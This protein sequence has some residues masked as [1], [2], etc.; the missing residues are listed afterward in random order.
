MVFYSANSGSMKALLPL[1]LIFSLHY[2]A[3]CQVQSC[4]VENTVWSE[5]FGTGTYSSL[6][7]GKT[8]YTYSSSTLVEGNYRLAKNSQGGQLWHNSKDHTG[9]T[10]G[11]M[12]L[13]NANGG[14]GE[15]YRDTVYNL[16]PGNF[17]MVSF[18]A[19]NT[20]VRGTC[21]GST[22]NPRLQFIAEA[23]NADGSF[24]QLSSFYSNYLNATS[25]PT[26]VKVSGNFTLPINVSAI[27]FRI[28]NTTTGTCGVNLAIDD[29]S[30]G[31]CA[32]AASLPAKGLNLT[33]QKRTNTVSL[34]WSTL[35]EFNTEKFEAEKS[36]D[37]RNWQ[38]IG[39][40]KA[41][42]NST[43]KKAYVMEDITAGFDQTYYRIKL[44]DVDGKLTYSNIQVVRD[45]EG[46]TA[47]R[48]V[49]NPFKQ[50]TTVQFSAKEDKL[51]T[52]RVSDL[53]GRLVFQKELKIYTGINQ[54][55]LTLDN[56]QK[57]IYHI[58]VM[59][60]DGGI[61]LRSKLVNL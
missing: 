43:Q 54:I 27:R 23:F 60:A 24:T 33:V 38:S 46:S 25:S 59:S 34:E 19:M 13:V 26:W 14:S 2:S 44:T 21:S 20:T 49:P 9:N 50:Q 1:L 5:T 29:I 18:Y 57:G 10:N 8:N 61:K 48:A 56:S 37:G 28:I 17:H 36:A 31:V 42:G 47:L 22:G 6:P 51:V 16:I 12:L 55:P 7:A 4:T 52:L 40:V 35:Q 3:R 15:I 58:D 11:L 41:A 45:Q 39:M 30:F 53:N 32:S